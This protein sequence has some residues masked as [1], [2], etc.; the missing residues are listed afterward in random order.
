MLTGT[1]PNSGVEYVQYFTRAF[2]LYAWKDGLC[3]SAF[4]EQTFATGIIHIL[5]FKTF[6][7]APRDKNPLELYL[8]GITAVIDEVPSNL[9]DT[10]STKSKL[11]PNDD[12][13]GFNR[14][15]GIARRFNF[16]EI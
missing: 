5:P 15:K 3:T 14:T 4:L 13:I 6:G 11:N 2:K 7:F 1:A 9:N 8:K 12:F 10:H 16:L